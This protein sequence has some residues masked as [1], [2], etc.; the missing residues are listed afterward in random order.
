M[1]AR[2]FQSNVPIESF[3]MLPELPAQGTSDTCTKTDKVAALSFS[4]TTNISLQSTAKVMVLSL[5][6][7]KNLSNHNTCQELGDLHFQCQDTLILDKKCIPDHIWNNRTQCDDYNNCLSQTGTLSGFVPLT[8]LQTYNGPTVDWARIPDII[9]AHKIVTKTDFPNIMA[10]RIAVQGQL[11]I[12]NWKKYLCNYWD[13]QLIDLLTFGFPLDFDR[14]VSLQT[15]LEN[16]KS[17]QQFP[18]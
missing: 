16:H 5:S 18:D 11:N 6:V 1:L 13:K 3:A 12:K 9:E 15:T 4:T 14:S 7:D 10:A 17:A 8:P 2:E